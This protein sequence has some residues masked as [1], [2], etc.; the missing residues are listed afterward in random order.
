MKTTKDKTKRQDGVQESRGQGGGMNRKKF[1]QTLGIENFNKPD[2]P[3]VT[4]P[5]DVKKNPESR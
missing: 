5:E 2:E 4:P 3:T 1:N